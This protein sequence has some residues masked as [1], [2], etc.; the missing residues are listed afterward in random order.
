ML[1][2]WS[3][4][5]GHF[6]GGAVANRDREQ[7]EST[8]LEPTRRYGV[9]RNGGLEDRVVS[10]LGSRLGRCGSKNCRAAVVVRPIVAEHVEGEDDAE[11]QDRRRGVAQNRTAMPGRPPA[12]VECNRA[13]GCLAV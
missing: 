8:V 10:R 1:D 9:G 5:A 7:C 13:R 6:P 11:N 4:A 12:R 2:E 3:L